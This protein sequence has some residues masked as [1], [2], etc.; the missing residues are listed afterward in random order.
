MFSSLIAEYNFD[1]I[2][3]LAQAELVAAVAQSF[4]W[5]FV[6]KKAIVP[7]ERDA[8]VPAS[9]PPRRKLNAIFER[10]KNM[11]GLGTQ[12]AAVPAEGLTQWQR[13]KRTFI[14]PSETFEDIRKGNHSWW[15]PMLVLA[16]AGYLL[17]AAVAQNI[18]IQQVLNNQIRM[19]PKASEQMAQATPE[20]REKAS[21]FWVGFTEGMFVA[22][23]VMGLV[24]IAIISMVLL[25][26]INF[27]FGGRARFSEIFTVCYYAWLPMVVKVLLGVAVIYAGQLP[28]SF[29]IKNYAPTNIGAFLDPT[30]TDKATYAL[31]SA[32][33]V[34]TVWTLLLMSMGVATVARV[35]RKAAYVSVFGW[36]MVVVLFR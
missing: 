1:Q 25:G 22:G 4:C 27:V 20:Q 6:E 24:S 29:N 18:G 9:G 21:K 17:F 16:L 30:A 32:L 36:W 14:A 5:K 2:S 3:T 33:D 19:N 12:S 11:T 35:G 31:A 10:G 28:E 7:T 15:M 26:T 23:P 34:I 8:A 13:V